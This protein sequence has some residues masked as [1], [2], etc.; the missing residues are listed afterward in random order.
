MDNLLETVPQ[1]VRN[2]AE[3]YPQIPAQMSRLLAPKD[4]AP[5]SFGSLSYQ[6]F[7][8]EINRFGA[9]LAAL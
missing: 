1:R 3:T 5:T 8:K 7:W 6:D 4:A 2:M 9:G